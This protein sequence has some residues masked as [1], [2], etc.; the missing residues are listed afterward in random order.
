MPEVNAERDGL[1]TTSSNLKPE[2]LPLHERGESQ[3]QEGQVG[4][5]PE[6][7]AKIG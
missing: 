6:P 3:Q 7:G 4:E 2:A 1:P 5:V